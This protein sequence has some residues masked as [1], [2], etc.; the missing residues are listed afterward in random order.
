MR[1]RMKFDLYKVFRCSSHSCFVHFFSFFLFCFSRVFLR[2]R[3]GDDGGAD[4]AD[5]TRPAHWREL[6]PDEGPAE[7]P[8][9]R[10]ECRHA[11]ACL[12]QTGLG[13]TSVPL[14][15]GR[16]ADLD[17]LPVPEG[18]PV[19]PGRGC[20]ALRPIEAGEDV[21]VYAGVVRRGD[22]APDSGYAFQL[23]HDSDWVVD[24]V[25]M[26]NITRFINDPRGM[27]REANVTA[28]EALLVN[29][30]I[31]TDPENMHGPYSENRLPIVLFQAIARIEPGEELLYE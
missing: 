4:G 7:A 8:W 30:E 12:L 31:E 15:R 19:H 17:V 18:H 20:Y 14:P 26:G 23:W 24:G 1:W 22:A 5:G 13:T 27:D 9:T 2:C 3:M 29:G 28:F 11:N 21:G 10:D 25:L 6:G 16:L